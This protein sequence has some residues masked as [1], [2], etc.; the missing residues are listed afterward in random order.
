MKK[1]GFIDYYISEWHANNYPAWIREMCE[2]DG[3]DY[4]ITY[5]WAELDISP[6]DGR[7]TEEWCQ[8]FG[9]EKCASI[10]ELCEKSDVLLILS[11]SN[12]EKHLGYARTALTY[13]KRTYIDKTFTPDA[14][15]AEEIFAVA[16][17]YNT[18]F[19]SSSA[20]RYATELADLNGKA[21]ITTG[22]GGSL[23]EYIVHQI[24]MVIRCFNSKALQVRLEQQDMQY[25][26]SIQFEDE[27]KATMIYAPSMGFMVSGAVD[28][29]PVT[30]SVDSEYFKALI[31]DILRFYDE[32][33]VSFQVEQ[34]LEVMRIRE[35]V[36]RAKEQLGEWISI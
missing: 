4:E 19:F 11:P 18:P 30:R 14:A 13:G 28:G 2:R 3:R 16:G 36:I 26:A 29:K 10:E 15:Q 35:A 6:V 27:K 25:I 33:N 31:A 12:P 17:K 24:E 23:D 5:A 9:V 32:G 8:A 1:I 22:G 20:L 7:S 34:T 21:L